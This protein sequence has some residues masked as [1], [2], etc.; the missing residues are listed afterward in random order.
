MFT[1]ACPSTVGLLAEHLKRP[2][3]PDRAGLLRF[4]VDL[5]VGD[6]D[7]YLVLR[8]I[9]E[10][11]LC[12]P[13]DKATWGAPYVSLARRC[14]AAGSKTCAVARKILATGTK[15]ERVSAAYLLTF[16]PSY[17]AMLSAKIV[18]MLRLERAPLV[19]AGLLLCLG[20]WARWRGSRRTPAVLRASL[21]DELPLVQ[22]CAAIALR[23]YGAMDDEVFQALS[24]SLY[25]P[26][27]P[28]LPWADGHLGDLAAAA[29]T[30]GT[31]QATKGVADSVASADI[32]DWSRG[33]RVRLLV[34]KVLPPER[35]VD[36]RQVHD[37]PLPAELTEPERIVVHMLAGVPE[38][39]LS[40]ASMSLQ[41]NGLPSYQ[42][43]LRRYLGLRAPGPMD[44]MVAGTVSGEPVRWP[45][46]RWTRRM[47]LG[48]IS[49]DAA[50]E[51]LAG[52]PSDEELLAALLE[53]LAA[54]D[55]SITGTL[56]WP[57]WARFVMDVLLRRGAS[58]AMLEKALDRLPSE[59]DFNAYGTLALLGTLARLARRL[60]PTYYSLV[61]R[62][63]ESRAAQELPDVLQSVETALAH[64]T[65]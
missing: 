43:E 52:H 9:R 41:A 26:R 5:S 62:V 35:Y 22:A 63:K 51:A 29:L 7:I 16:Y 58:P 53:G 6:P 48:T 64:P 1:D 45:A 55:L 57:T 14:Y 61:Q 56:D 37:M 47:G 3:T 38:P 12:G 17:G 36:S 32:D 19:R 50:I 11:R 40:I 27:E 15:A 20:Y 60:P 30:D 24:L 2:Q 13:K 4:V 18:R 8:H 65:T 46:H 49:R 33:I 23:G 28:R 54:Y 21:R 25:L 34:D 42:P 10:V 39:T 31:A 59:K 44:V